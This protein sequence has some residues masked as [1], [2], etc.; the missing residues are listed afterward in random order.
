MNTDPT[1]LDPDE[2]ARR[3]A[4][5]RDT[6][7][8]LRRTLHA[9][10]ARIE[11][12]DRLAG[13]LTEAH[14]ETS[15]RGARRWLAPAA[16]AA[17]ALLLAGTV[18]AVDRP[19][20]TAPV[21]G[22]TVASESTGAT[23]TPTSSGPSSSTPSASSSAATGRPSPTTVTVSPTVPPEVPPTVP[24]RVPPTVPPTTGSP[25]SATTI[26]LPVYYLGPVVAGSERLRL[27]RE[28][29]PAVVPAPVTAGGK[30]LAAL[31][32]AFGA[33]GGSGPRAA[34]MPRRGAPPI[35]PRSRSATG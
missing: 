25:P 29:V 10:A 15:G 24:P 12:T 13:I 23:T 33:T 30:A 1:P 35:R 20:G 22:P 17:A 27:F 11:P 2:V 3:E 19:S 31:R 8:R 5:L 16:A 9:D 14:D 4:A 26:T 18:W 21:G 28:F 6:E 34:A 7:E 32:L